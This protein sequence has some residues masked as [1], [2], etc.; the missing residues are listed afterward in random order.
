MYVNKVIQKPFVAPEEAECKLINCPSVMLLS[1]QV[2]LW[3]M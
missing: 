1:G 2:A 3:I